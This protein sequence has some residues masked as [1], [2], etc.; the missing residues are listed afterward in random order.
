MATWVIDMFH[1]FNFA[2]KINIANNS[3]DTKANEK[4]NTYLKTLELKENNVGF[5]K[6]KKYNFS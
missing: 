3:T 5:T 2:K 4:I 6:L 1:N